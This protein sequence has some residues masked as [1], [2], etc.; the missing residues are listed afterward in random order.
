MILKCK[1]RHKVQDEMYG[2][3]MRVHNFARKG[4]SDSKPGWR[5]TVCGNVKY[6]NANIESL[7]AGS[8]E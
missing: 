3:Q 8:V 4:F 7:T 1:C 2:S 6:A 5:C